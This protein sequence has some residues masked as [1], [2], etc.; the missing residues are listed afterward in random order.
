MICVVGAEGAPWL[1]SV[2]AGAAPGQAPVDLASLVPLG[3]RVA[4]L[5]WVR[6]DARRRV[7]ARLLA[8]RIADGV[9]ALRLPASCRLVI[10][11]AG[12]A[13]RTFAVARARGVATMLVHDLPVLRRLHHDLDAAARRHPE[14]PLLRRYRA[15]ARDVARQEAERVLADRVVVLGAFARAALLAAGLPADRLVPARSLPV[16]PARPPPPG[17]RRVLLAGLATTRNGAREALEAITQLGDVELLVRAGDGLDPPNLLRRRGVRV[18]T[19]VEQRSL[20]GVHAVI[21]PAWCECY[22]PEVPL[23]ARLGVPVLATTRAAGEVDLSRAGAELP[24]G[25]VPA[26]RRAIA[27]FARDEPR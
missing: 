8:R 25:D 20:D 21:A 14:A 18:A 13:E 4:N 26:L 17:R 11:P 27:S 24:A 15:S 16:T 7:Q 3:L 9:A 23:A 12:A 19:A 22:P 1:E 6:R 10:A 2:P 5:A